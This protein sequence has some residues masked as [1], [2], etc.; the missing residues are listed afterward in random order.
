MLL[1]RSPHTPLLPLEYDET[2]LIMHVNVVLMLGQRRR[3]SPN[4]KTTLYQCRVLM[5]MA[6][7]ILALFEGR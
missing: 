6:C 4:I 5:G 2:Q 7:H 3:R 1:E